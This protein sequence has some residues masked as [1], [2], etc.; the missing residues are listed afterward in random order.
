MLG[1]KFS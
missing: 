1:F